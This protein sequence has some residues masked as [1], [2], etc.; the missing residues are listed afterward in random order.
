MQEGL[1]AVKL[2]VLTIRPVFSRLV[3]ST[4]EAYAGRIERVFYESLF[5]RDHHPDPEFYKPT[6]IHEL[7]E[8]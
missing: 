4:V 8:P 6:Y 7:T 5:V 3:L 1:S 2:P